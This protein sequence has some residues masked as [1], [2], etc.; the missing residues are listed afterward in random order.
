MPF[1][2]SSKLAKECYSTTKFCAADF[3]R[4]KEEKMTVCP[5][6]KFWDHI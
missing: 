4:G 2:V 6:L 5:R 1:W 3:A